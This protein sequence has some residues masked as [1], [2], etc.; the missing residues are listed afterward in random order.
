MGHWIDE[1]DPAVDNVPIVWEQFQIEFARQFQDSQREDRARIKI[2]NVRMRFPEVDEYIAQFEELA[3]QAGYTQGNPETT[4]LF[5]KG[6]TKSILEDVLKPP[7]V[8]GY[9]AIKERAIQSTK[10]KQMIESIVGRRPN[11]GGTTG[12]FQ[13]PN[14]PG[15]RGGAF[16]NFQGNFQNQRRPF[17]SNNN[18]QGPQRQQFTSSNAPRW[19]NN[20]AVPMDLDRA[21]APTWRRGGQPSRGRVFQTN[22]RNNAPPRNTSNT[23]FNCGQEGHFA[24]SCPRRQNQRGSA[25]LIDLDDDYYPEP[26]PTDPVDE[27]RAR[28]ESLTLD[29]Q[30]RLAKEMEVK[31]DFPT[32]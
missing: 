7:F 18:P 2:E 15:F 22:P 12:G 4:Q 1:L 5:L 24:R 28:L 20:T 23:C 3:R 26:E 8:H 25:N 17:H 21:R 10:S 9:P 11:Q 6:L 30:T 16:R 29:Q 32:V 13:R 27:V 19:L 31:E 14:N